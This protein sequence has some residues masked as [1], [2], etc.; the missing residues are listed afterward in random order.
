MSN[1]VMRVAR[2]AALAAALLLVSCSG[3]SGSSETPA[4][5]CTPVAEVCNG[6]DE[7]CDGVVDDGCPAVCTPAAVFCDDDGRTLHTCNAEGTSAHPGDDVVCPFTCLDGQC[8]AA[9]N[10]PE[11]F[12]AGCGPGAPPLAPAAG[13]VVRYVGNGITCSTDCGDGATFIPVTVVTTATGDLAAA[14]LSRLE[15]PA[16]VTLDHDGSPALRLALV[17]DGTARIAGAIRFDGGTGSGS[18]G[19]AGRSGGSAGPGGHAGAAGCTG[20]PC[21][22]RPGGG[23]GAGGAATAAGQYGGG[24]GGASHA[25]NGAAGGTGGTIGLGGV[26]GFTYGAG[27]TAPL[28]GGSGG[29]SGASALTGGG[30]GP[31]GG[32]GGAIQISARGALTVPEGGVV[33]AAGGAGG[34]ESGGHGGGGGGS[35][36]TVVLQAR[37]VGIAGMEQVSANGGG[38]GASAGAG[39][40][41][42]TMMTQSS[43]AGGSSATGGGGGGGGGRG[44]VIVLS[45]FPDADADGVPD[46]EDACPA[47]PTPGCVPM[48]AIRGPERSVAPGTTV[49]L[50]GV[51]VTAVKT[52]PT[53]Q[54][55]IWVQDPVA[56]E[57]GGI[58][59]L[60]G[61]SALPAVAVGDT[62]RVT[63]VYTEYFGVSQIY[64]SPEV[65]VTSVVA[66]IVIPI[67]VADPTRIATGGDLAEPLEGMLVRIG[68]VTVTSANPDAPS[69]YDE[70]QV[71]GALRVDDLI[72]DGT[73]DG[74][75]AVVLD[76][77]FTSITGIL[78]FTMN[79][80][81]LEPRS[82]ADLVP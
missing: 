11:A 47:D 35:G 52:W 40:A 80:A 79:D 69:D 74:N 68:G 75:P 30:S 78:H 33:S 36:G 44:R 76:Q 15:L 8:V 59:V 77:T 82:A 26:G 22:G 81:K 19:T 73:N 41:G 13:Q 32:G 24:G 9:A 34:A 18:P 29:G 1:G 7:N 20:A 4:A 50:A 51:I 2:G 64:Q 42:A 66:A 3:G 71:A 31:G 70:F 6:L 62:V 57:Y 63:G 39:G 5:G 37:S 60:F 23:P 16:G 65:T 10:V 49:T 17:V 72:L 54:K 67:A 14:C 25:S 27:G 45:S 48:A 61:A 38:G 28:E 56:T 21:S 55:A 43:F 58:E 53:S 46:G 12:V